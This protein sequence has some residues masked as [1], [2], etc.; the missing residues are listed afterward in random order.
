M[1]SEERGR[2][3]RERERERERGREINFHAVAS[4]FINTILLFYFRVPKRY[5]ISLPKY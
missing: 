5:D 4:I 2:E 3:G 1:K